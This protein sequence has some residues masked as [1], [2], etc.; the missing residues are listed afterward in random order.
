MKEN[1][2]TQPKIK[3]GNRDYNP[4]QQTTHI[5]APH[6]QEWLDSAVAPAI[7]ANNV[8]SL[9]GN[10][11]YEYL[12]YSDDIK[13]LNTGRLTSGDLKKYSHLD[14]G[15]WWVNG[16][17]PLTGEEQLWGQFKSDTPRVILEVKGDNGFGGETIT[18][19]KIIK[20]EAPPKV[21]T[22]AMFLRVTWKISRKVA[23]RTYR[24]TKDKGIYRLWKHRAKE[25]F[26][27]TSGITYKTFLQ[28]YQDTEF[29]QWVLE[30]SEVGICI[31]EGAKK[32][33]ALLTQGIAAISLAGIWNGCP[34]PK[35]KLGNK[36]GLPRL[37][38]QLALFATEGREI[39]ICFDQDSQLKTRINVKK[40]IERLGGLFSRAGCQVKILT[41]DAPE[42]GVDDLIADKG[43]EYFESVYKSRLSLAEYKIQ[44]FCHLIPD[45]TIKEP[46]IPESLQY[47]QN[48]KLIGVRSLYG[49]GKTEWLAKK[50]AYYL[51]NRQKV[52][53][54]VHREQLARE[55]ARRFGINYRTEVKDNQFFGQFGYAL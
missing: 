7:I 41:W 32:A 5:K 16:V 54:I 19:E 20:Y 52:I 2:G 39:S 48:A 35:D 27:Q 36:I 55:L 29:W 37:L 33:G 34:V 24:Q 15:G 53:I 8:K 12:F 18:K 22:E 45:L 11:P 31:T 13:R 6:Y 42:K 30:N 50:I 3:D 9:S 44:G 47:P 4:S 28:D 14:N 21:P 26:K 43:L 40:A 38:P 10:T 51:A 46:Y 17:N 23:L 25:A 49:T 1:T